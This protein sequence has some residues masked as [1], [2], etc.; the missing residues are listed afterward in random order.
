VSRVVF[1]GLVWLDIGLFVLVGL[2][3][4]AHCIGIC[5]PLVT[6]YAGRM[7]DRRADGR[8]VSRGDA[9]GAPSPSTRS[10]ST[11]CST[12]GGPR[13]TPPRAL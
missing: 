3:E 11:R 9:R 7:D 6:V 1:G 8:T 12:S 5:G 4:G 2:L 10:A 13:A